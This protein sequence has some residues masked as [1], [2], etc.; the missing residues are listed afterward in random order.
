MHRPPPAPSGAP[1]GR[2]PDPATGLPPA[3]ARPLAEFVRH[4]ESER[5]R[6]PHT[7]RAYAGDI[8]GAL[9]HAAEAGATDVAGLDLPLLRGWLA[10]A[11]AAGASRATLA[12]RA[13]SVRAFTAWLARTG[14]VGAD[15]AL[16]L[17]APRRDGTLPAVL[18][19]RTMSDLLDVADRRT[20][21]RAPTHLRDAAALEM[22]YATGMRVGEL[23]GLDVGDVD[24]SRRTVRVLGKGA[25]ERVVPYGAPAERALEEYLRA[26]RPRLLGPGSGDALWLGARGSRW[27][28]RGARQT[29]QALSAAVASR[30]VSPHTLRHSAATHLLDGGADLRSVQEMLGHASLATTQV[31]T[32]VSVDRLRASYRQAHPRA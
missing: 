3:L 8:T 26:G 31:Y 13:S 19:A 14:L 28:Q 17:R 5:R 16:R 7:V 25:K 29:V 10:A 6:S 20:D 12:R 15:P 18:D 9:A 1:D 27:G 24:R 32:H 21:D 22:L 23:V 30:G 11:A 4:L 2:A